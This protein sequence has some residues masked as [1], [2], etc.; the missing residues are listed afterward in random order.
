MPDTVSKIA[1]FVFEN[2]AMA[3]QILF[4][5]LDVDGELPGLTP[6]EREAMNAAIPELRETWV[7]LLT[8]CREAVWQQ[9]EGHET[10]AKLRTGK[11]QAAKMWEKGH[12]KM[13]LL[14]GGAAE[15]G[16]SLQC[17]E[18]SAKYQLHVWVWTQA[19]IRP[20]AERALA[21][22]KPAPWQNEIGTFLLSLGTPEQGANIEAL[23]E[24]AAAALWSMARPIA[25][26]ITA[27]QRA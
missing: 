20:I 11:T 21:D 5:D 4:R 18:G 8:A 22:H 17:W 13:P 6:E 12:V 3:D 7:T 10:E 15:C 19:R 26:A 23:A 24:G 2:G 14:P 27:E 16:V 1:S 9:A 25:E